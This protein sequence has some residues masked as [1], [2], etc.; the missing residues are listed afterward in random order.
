MIIS[1]QLNLRAERS[2]ANVE[3]NRERLTL[4]RGTPSAP[5]MIDR[6]EFSRA[7]RRIGTEQ[8]PDQ[9]STAAIETSSAAN[10]DAA[11]EAVDG[12]RGLRVLLRLIEY[13]TGRV[14]RIFDASELHPAGQSADAAS[15]ST[16]T[17]PGADATPVAGTGG[18]VI[19]YRRDQ[20]IDERELTRFHAEGVIRTADGQELRFEIELQMS[21]HYRLE[22]SERVQIGA[23]AQRKDPLVINFAGH[24]AKLLD[25]RFAF[26]L[27]AD[28]ATDSL[29]LLGPGSGYITFDRNR[30]GV[31]DNGSE[32]FGTRSGDGY[33]DLRRLDSDG[34]GWID[35]GD[36]AFASLGVW[37]PAQQG[38]GRLLSLN[39][40]GVRALSVASIGTEFALRGAQNR[41]LGQIRATGLYLGATGVVGTTQQVDLSV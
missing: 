38:A 20:V 37:W 23:A 41:D 16:V 29:A 24:A 30:N 14:A 35:E 39:E 27:D 1:S 3:F 13:L 18:V 5:G 6:A 25:Q 32:L 34:N 33:A 2:Y 9:S 7:A 15:T 22:T 8:L 26:D 36:S 12:G 17:R 11:A 4:Q 21:R 31:V 28:G 19:D 40:A 10:L